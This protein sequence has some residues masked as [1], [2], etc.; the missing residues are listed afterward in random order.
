MFPEVASVGESPCPA[1][2]AAGDPDGSSADAGSGWAGADATKNASSKQPDAVPSGQVMSLKRAEFAPA[3]AWSGPAAMAVH[4][5][6][7]VLGLS[8]WESCWPLPSAV[9][10][11]LTL[12]PASAVPSTPAWTPA[13]YQPPGETGTTW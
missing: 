5:A 10:Y 3:G 7:R 8:S 1:G 2:N 13:A 4:V 11:Q 12:M 9:A 6:E